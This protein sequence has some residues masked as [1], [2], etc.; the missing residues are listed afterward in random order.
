M[1]IHMNKATVSPGLI[2]QPGQIEQERNSTLAKCHIA[3]NIL[4]IHA[5]IAQWQ[6]G[7]LAP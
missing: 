5:W 3:T 7:S 1:F 2:R 4:F 6:S